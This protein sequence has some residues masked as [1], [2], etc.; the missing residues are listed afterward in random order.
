M[1]VPDGQIHP[2]ILVGAGPGDPDLI[3]LAGAA[4]LRRAEVVLYDRLVAA[5]LLKLAA[6]AEL[7]DVGKSPG[8]A[9]TPQSQINELLVQHAQAGR[10]V[11]R[12]KGGD[13]FVFGRG[14]E[15]ASALSTAGVPFQVTPGVTS[16]TAAAAAAGIAVTDRRAASALTIVTGSLGDGDAPPI[17]WN[18]V[19]SVGGTIVVM[20]GWGNFDEIAGRLIAGGLDSETPSAAI[21]RASTPAQRVVTAPLSAL[22]GRATG[23]RP[24]V[25]VVIGPTLRL[26]PPTSHGPLSGQRI[27]VTRPELQAESL[28]R[29]L[30]DLGAEVVTL[31][32]IRIEPADPGP[33]DAA[34][35]GLAKGQY[36]ALAL[37]SV[38]GVRQLWNGLRRNGLD[39]RALAGTS[40]AAIGLETS[41]E[42]DRHGLAADIVPSEFTSAA[43]LRE[44]VGSGVQGVRVLLARATRASRLL[45]DGLHKAGAIVDDV[46]LYD[47]I[48]PIPSPQALEEL[49]YGVDLVTLT[50]PSTAHGLRELAADTLDLHSVQSVCI[51]PVTADAARELGFRVVAT[52]DE[53]TMDGLVAA[54][55]RHVAGNQRHDHERVETA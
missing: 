51:G 16:A 47:T 41:R 10:R 52:A 36:D 20:M 23:M 3:T 46:A 35:A 43:L 33:I 4:A 40:V 15:E 49:Q 1:S 7:I 6:D 18:A 12:L 27:L 29:R 45:S 53:H 55:V 24:P 8:G 48:T 37:T 44:L 13:P 31:P 17:D 32:S 26:T 54:V 19:A 14:G 50:S 22:A 9:S 28:V 42:L 25:T 30:R 2:V 11:V 5:E 39:A 34:I 38:N 21:E